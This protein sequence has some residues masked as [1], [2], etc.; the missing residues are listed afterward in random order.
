MSRILHRL[1]AVGASLR[2]AVA[3]EVKDV[4]RLVSHLLRGGVLLSVA[5]LVAGFVAAAARAVPLPTSPDPL[6]E[7]LG[8]ALRLDP[9][10]L[11]S[12]AVLVM[13]ATPVARVVLTLSSFL[14]QRDLRFA[15]VAGIVL[16]N[17]I[18][19]LILGAL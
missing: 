10:G 11:L 8:D 9:S 4:N 2:R 12:L 16:L 5:V 13:I 19:G 1:E 17:L 15:A 14:K 18:V 3:T 7:V 6:S